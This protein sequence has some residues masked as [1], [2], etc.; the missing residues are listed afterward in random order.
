MGFRLELDQNLESA[1]EPMPQPKAPGFFKK[2][3]SSR[4]A[5]DI[6]QEEITQEPIIGEPEIVNDLHG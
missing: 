4:K 3:F 1:P 6:V 5:K 2:I